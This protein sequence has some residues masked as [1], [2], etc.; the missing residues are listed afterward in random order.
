MLNNKKIA[1]I[2]PAYNAEKTLLR[3]Y[4]EIPKDV[5]DDI[6]LV[7]DASTDKTVEIARTLDIHVVVHADNCGYGANQRTCYTEAL[8]RGA[9]VVVMLH[10]DYQYP[11][12]LVASMAEPIASGQYDVIFSSR[13]LE[14]DPRKNGMPNSTYFAN[15]F[16]TALQNLFLKHN[17]S[18]IHSGYRAF[19]REVLMNVPIW[20]N[21]DGFIFETQILTQLLY[22]GYTIGGV[23][24]TCLYH[25]ESSS[26]GAWRTVLFSL[27]SIKN[28]MQYFLEKAGW[29]HYPMYIKRK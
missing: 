15:R 20:E 23:P 29:K 21:D 13:F 9:D 3:T 8:K 12:K 11:P 27:R 6:I 17:L 4:E 18:E 7:D 14:G 24:T 28:I 25:K 26:I 22:F 10:P 2:M 19:S 1:V 16:S 5:V